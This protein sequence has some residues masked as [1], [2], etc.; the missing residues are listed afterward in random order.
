MSQDQTSAD[1]MSKSEK[2]RK[3]LRAGAM[4]AFSEL[5]FHGA[6]TRH[7]ATAAGMS[8]AAVYVHY[9]SKEELLYRISKFGHEAIL[10]VV[11]D[12]AASSDDPAEQLRAYA[13]ALAKY[14]AQ[15]HVSARVVNYELGALEPEHHAEII[16]LRQELDR[17]V[18]A[19]LQRGL[20]RGVFHTANL[21]MT[22]VTIV[23]ACIDIARWYRDGGSWTP[24][25][26][27]RFYADSALRIAGATP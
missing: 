19:I 25:D 8:P 18:D 14:H 12:G 15:E 7:I 13:F 26:V 2:T 20:D 3:R 27:G 22:S 23:G 9:K 11:R 1:S 16:A 21:R 4:A 6:S 24:D 5:G 17:V 10:A